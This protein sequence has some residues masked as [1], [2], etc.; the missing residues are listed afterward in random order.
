MRLT[1][2]PMAGAGPEK[3]S[4]ITSK[5]SP[6]PIY[7]H[8]SWRQAASFIQRKHGIRTDEEH[9]DSAQD[10]QFGHRTS[11]AEKHYGIDHTAMAS[12]DA[13]TMLLFLEASRSWHAILYCGTG[14]QH[15]AKSS[16][17]VTGVASVH[18][19]PVI[20]DMHALFDTLAMCWR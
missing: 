1:F 5:S 14:S 9:G 13:S 19:T 17:V 2:S 15:Q 6:T 16:E 18:N 3:T 10:L 11:T 12:L 20:P 7:S 4:A 8:A